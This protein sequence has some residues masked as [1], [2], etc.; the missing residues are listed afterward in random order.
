MEQT[1]Q[2]LI[3]LT[4]RKGQT[5]INITHSNLSLRIMITLL[6][7]PNKYFLAWW[8]ILSI[9]LI[10]IKSKS[11]GPVTHSIISNAQ[12]KELDIMTYVLA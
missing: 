11:S 7:M 1:I 10:V 5:E 9:C 8:L 12:T 6:V 2:C 4:W 3:G